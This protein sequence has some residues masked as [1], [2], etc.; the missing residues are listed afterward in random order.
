MRDPILATA[1]AARSSPAASLDSVAGAGST[2]SAR[3]AKALNAQRPR[4]R[5]GEIAARLLKGADD[6]GRAAALASPACSPAAAAVRPRRVLARLRPD[7]FG[8]GA[9]SDPETPSAVLG[10][11]CE[12][13]HGTDVNILALCNPACPPRAKARLAATGALPLRRELA[14]AAACPADLLASL[15][16]DDSDAGVQA[17][18]AC[19]P[20]CPPAAW[21][22]LVSNGPIG[23]RIALAEESDC[24]AGALTTLAADAEADVRRHVAC[25]TRASSDLVSLLADDADTGVRAAAAAHPHCRWRVLLDLADDDAAEVRSAVA[26]NQSTPKAVVDALADDDDDGVR[27]GVAFNPTCPPSTLSDLT[28]DKATA[29]A[30]AASDAM[31]GWM[32]VLAESDDPYARL[33]AAQSDLCPGPTLEALT[34]DPDPDVAAAASETLG[35][36]A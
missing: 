1:R 10:R 35:Y 22:R 21:A 36:E 13:R 23:A 8:D 28:A 19:N 6:A 26:A 4:G 32:E 17:R 5:C 33:E 9:V 3:L 18:A 27:L 34:E 29:V 2:K 7:E 14:S 12:A 30:D 15:C 31:G 20:Q 24:P 16:V 11:L 25:N